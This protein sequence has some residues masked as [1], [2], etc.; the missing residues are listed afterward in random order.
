MTADVQPSAFDRVDPWP[1]RSTSVDVVPTVRPTDGSRTYTPCPACAPLVHA[2][3][4]RL[5][6]L[7]RASEARDRGPMRTTARE[8]GVGQTG[9]KEPS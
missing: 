5:D 2:M 3:Q 8:H 6:E 7:Q 1:A 4:D 9:W